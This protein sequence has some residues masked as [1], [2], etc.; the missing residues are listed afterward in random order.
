MFPFIASK[1]SKGACLIAA[2]DIKEGALVAKF[3]GK[4]TDYEDVPESEIC[5]VWP[6]VRSG[7]WVIIDTDVRYINHSC[8]PNCK[9]MFDTLEL[10]AACDIPN[11]QELTIS[12]VE[13]RKED[14]IKKPELFFWDEKWTFKCLC[15]SD[16][17]R[18][19]VDKYHFIE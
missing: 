6:D 9:V 7:K 8:N 3:T 13:F 14:F 4:F 1:N 2:Q 10:V 5:Y 15:G 17:C 12:Y 16:H 18:G 11:G 19:F